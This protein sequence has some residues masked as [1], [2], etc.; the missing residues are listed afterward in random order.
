MHRLGVKIEPRHL[1]QHG[2]G[3]GLVFDDAAQRRCD[4]ALRQD[5]GGDLIEQRLKQVMVGAVDD[6]DVDVGVGQ[7]LGHAEPPE[8][9]ADHQDLMTL[10]HLRHLLSIAWDRRRAS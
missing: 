4:H 7:R 2:A 1:G 6:R 8:T 9:A 3:V 10:G 5:P